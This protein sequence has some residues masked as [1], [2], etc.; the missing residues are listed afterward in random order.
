MKIPLE[1]KNQFQNSIFSI[2][3]K[4]PL[5]HIWLQQVR[6]FSHSSHKVTLFM[7]LCYLLLLCLYCGVCVCLSCQK[8]NVVSIFFYVIFLPM[9]NCCKAM[10]VSCRSDLGSVSPPGAVP[11]PPDPPRSSG[12][13]SCSPMSSMMMTSLMRSR[14]LMRSPCWLLSGLSGQHISRQWQFTF[15]ISLLPC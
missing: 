7:I 8:Q 1:K 2:L 4:N 10:C 15:T 11:S 9:E 13:I 6:Y 3:T 5:F 14:V 12:S